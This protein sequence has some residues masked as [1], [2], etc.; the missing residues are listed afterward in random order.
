M[1]TGT[2]RNQRTR[3]LEISNIVGVAPSTTWMVNLVVCTCTI[4]PINIINGKNK[5][6]VIENTTKSTGT[7]VQGTVKNQMEIVEAENYS[8]C[9]HMCSL[10]CPLTVEFTRPK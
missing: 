5:N 2:S 8:L 10:H 6:R 1:N 7:N 4:Q 3:L 9:A